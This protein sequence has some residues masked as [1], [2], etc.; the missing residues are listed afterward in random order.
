VS[1]ASAELEVAADADAGNWDVGIIG[2]MSTRPIG[3]YPGRAA[4]FTGSVSSGCCAVT[5][6]KTH[7]ILSDSARPRPKTGQT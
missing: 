1:G 3:E 7:L 2:Q 5:D 6:V 4:S